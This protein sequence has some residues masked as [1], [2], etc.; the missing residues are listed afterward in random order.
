MSWL[1]DL[2]AVPY[3]LLTRQAVWAEQSRRLLA[4]LPL[5]RAAERALDVGCGPGVS[6]VALV[7]ALPRARVIGLDISAG[8]LRRAREHVG[9]RDRVSLLAAD[10][11]RLPLADDSVD[12]ATGHSFLYLVPDP[13]GVLREV[14]RAVRPGG[15]AGFLEP[16]AGGSLRQAARS[17][18]RSG[19]W[20]G[21][22][23]ERLRFS[24]SMVLWRTFSGA[25]GRLS[26]DAAEGLLRA[27]GF[28]QVTATPTLGGLGLHVR[29]R[30]DG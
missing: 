3:D 6:T 16:R 29:G 4:T 20:P 15:W 19:G 27:A 13:V 2:G 28:G 23:L 1:F 14:A 26:E 7:E 10:G 5:D 25:V 30:V 18:V 21:G 8:M 12:V 9:G 17:A 24:A 11:L 22:P